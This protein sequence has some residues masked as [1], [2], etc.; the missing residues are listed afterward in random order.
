MIHKL[1]SSSSL[2]AIAAVGAFWMAPTVAAGQTSGGATASAPAVGLEEL[3]VTAQRRAE[4]VQDVPISLVAVSGASLERSG[5]RTTDDLQRMAPGL[6]IATVGSGFVSYT[7]IRGGGTNQVDTGSDPS[8]AYFVDEVYLGGS[9]GLQF[10][11]FD[12][13]HVE[14]LKGPQGTLFGRNA[15]SGAISIVTRKPSRT[16]EGNIT[17]EYGNYNA[18]LV[19]GGVSGPLTSD[20]RLLYRISA[21]I[22]QRDA[23]TQNLTGLADP[24]NLDSKGAR[25]QLEWQDGD[26]DLLLTGDVLHARNGQTNQ[27]LTGP[28]TG[29]FLDP[30]LPLP[31]GQSFF[32]H[33]YDLVGH[34]NQDLADLTARADYKTS[35]GTITSITAL[36]RSKFTRLQDNDMTAYNGFIN[37]LYERDRTFSQELR[38]TG[39]RDRFHYILGAY[40]YRAKS[41][42]DPIGIAGPA[43]PTV[44]ARGRQ[45]VDL[46]AITTDSYAA[47]GQFSYDLT[48]R[49]KLTLGGRYTRDEKRESRHVDRFGLAV[50]D[51]SP[52]ANFHRFTPAVTLDW[53]P[54]DGVLA[55]ASYREGYKSGG[56]QSTLPPTPTLASTPFLPEYVKSYEAGLKLTLLERRL[57]ADFALF[58]SDITN[59]QVARSPAPATLLIDNAGRTRDDG[60]DVSLTARPFEALTLSAD[61]TF[62]RARFLS[63]R[64]IPQ[65]FD[66]KAQLRSPDFSGFFAAEYVTP[67]PGAGDLA[68]RAEYAYRTKAFF[69]AANSEISGL[70]QPAYGVANL[71]AALRPQGKDLEI[72]A[73]VRNV[74]DTH[75]YQNVA[76]SGLAGAAAPGQP[77][78]YG[79]SISARF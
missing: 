60:L 12:I 44:V 57:L 11:L 52:H 10:D 26:L 35:L 27:F 61:M 38:L 71:R 64:N 41:D 43:F 45:A 70:F 30:T 77:R 68:L 62:Q 76:I 5:V 17:L 46:M 1:M 54:T 23:F 28:T 29:G 2:G 24:G 66:G 6:T 69:D 32:A 50:Y 14:V 48:E 20:G 79:V 34:E 67:L 25:G 40:Y 65:N 53:K 47:F 39:D 19:R 36:R 78:T 49:L 59:Q 21:N 8:V 13:D 51:V 72:A 73:F 3:V 42:Y 37:A 4:D 75:Y 58:R 22:R 15:A 16:P 56:F 63:Y 55:Y 31:P 9:A 74:G 18:V 7:Y 33:Y